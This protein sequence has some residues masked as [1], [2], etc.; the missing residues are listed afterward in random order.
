[1]D[2]ENKTNSL[3]GCFRKEKQV[4]VASIKFM[5]MMQKCKDNEDCPEP[6]HEWVFRDIQDHQG[7]MLGVLLGK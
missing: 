7:K 4:S 2:T 6:G 5:V 1:L 3:F